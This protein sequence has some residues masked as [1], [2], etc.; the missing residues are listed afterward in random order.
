M[1][2]GTKQLSPLDIVNSANR[3]VEQVMPVLPFVGFF[4]GFFL[5]RIFIGVNDLVPLIFGFMTLSGAMNLRFRELGRAASSPRAFLFFFLTTRILIPL[6][7]FLLISPVLRND[8]DSISGLVLIYAVPMAVTSFMWVTIYKGDIA[9]V[10]A[11]IF[12]DTMMAPLVVPGTIRL[13]LGASVSL[14]TKGMVLSLIYIIVIPTVIGVTLNESSRGK[15]PRLI[16]PWFSPVSKLCMIPLIAANSAYVAPQI[17][18]DN[19]HLWIIFVACILLNILGFT[20]GK[21]MGV[22]GKFDREKQITIFMGAGLRNN[23]VAMVL[24]MQFF[25]PPAALPAVLGVITQHIIAGIM[26]RILMKKTGKDDENGK[27]S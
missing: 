17:R 1:P 20:I 10:L 26:G 22:L 27:N 19:P 18:L 21:I 11:F 13:L 7:V 24:G 3:F 23:S 2:E 5:H 12:L 16:S 4:L 15:I 9:L 6:I 25:A 8:P 14:D